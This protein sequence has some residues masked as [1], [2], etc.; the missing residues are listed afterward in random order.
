[1][2]FFVGADIAKAMQTFRIFPHMHDILLLSH[3]TLCLV[4]DRT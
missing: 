3:F 2:I 4:N 1:M